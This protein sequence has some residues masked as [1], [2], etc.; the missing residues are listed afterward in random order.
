M[1]LDIKKKFATDPKKESEG[2]WIDLEDQAKVKIRRFTYL[3]AQKY[4]QNKLKPYR[5]AIEL[6]ALPDNVME[7]I[8]NELLA[9]HLVVDWRNFTYGQ[10]EQGV[11]KPLSCTPANILMVL[12][13][14]PE[15]RDMLMAFSRSV[16]LYKLGEDEADT[17]N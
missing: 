14:L 11:D 6:D 7:K 4:L 2:V 17:K 16:E 15:L 8:Q 3:P 10:D 9:N 13:E 1:A 5:K 12:K